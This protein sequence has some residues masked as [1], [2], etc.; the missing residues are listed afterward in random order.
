MQPLLRS[1]LAGVA[2]GARSFS[3]VA[4]AARTPGGLGRAESLLH[5]PRSRKFLTSSALGELAGDKLP[6]TPPRTQLPSLLFR[7][8]TGALSGAVVARRG[9]GTALAGGLVGAATSAAWT[10][11]GPAYRTALSARFGSDVPGALLEDAAALGLAAVA[12]R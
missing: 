2:S 6:I 3:A 9:G 10:Y 7:V 8:A 5:G 12:T 4:A 1:A 11:A